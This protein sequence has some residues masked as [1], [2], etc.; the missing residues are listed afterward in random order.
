MEGWLSIGQIAKKTKIPETT[1]RRYA[2]T[3]E[4]YLESEKRGRG[5]KYSPRAQELIVQI[6]SLYD[7]GYGTVEIEDIIRGQYPQTVDVTNDTDSGS[8]MEVSAIWELI[9]KQ[10]SEIE[11]LRKEL[12][13]TKSHIA[14]T[15][16]ERDQKLVETM[17]LMLDEK[18][19][20]WWKRI[21]S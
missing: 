8:L 20:P 6:S 12:E 16:E 18:K 14:N 15:I 9:K 13:E 21:F 2:A 10:Q 7:L 4:D 11:E 5:V 3:F 17:R 1:L 19:R